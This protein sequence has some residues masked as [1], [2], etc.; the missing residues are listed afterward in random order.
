MDTWTT[1]RAKLMSAVVVGSRVFVGRYTIA[2]AK[3]K[4]VVKVTAKQ[5]VLDGDRQYNTYWRATGVQTARTTLRENIIAVS[6]PEQ[7]AEYDRKASFEHAK[8]NAWQAAK[9]GVEDN[10]KELQVF[11]DSK[12]T[13]VYVHPDNDTNKDAY[14]VK[15]KRLWAVTVGDLTKDKLKALV[16]FLGS[17]N[18]AST[19]GRLLTEGGKDE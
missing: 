9:L 14:P 11:T 17:A 15:A 12:V 1:E 18:Y 3:L 10:C 6:T 16:T 4:T 19:V 13:G 8:Q 2:S 7:A 5:V